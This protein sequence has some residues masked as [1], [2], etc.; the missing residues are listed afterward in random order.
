MPATLSTITTT[1]PADQRTRAV[2]VW[3]AVAGG[4][5][6]LG[7]LCSGV[8][9]EFF[10]WRSVFVVNIV[11]AVMAL[12]GTLRFVPESAH[13]ATSR[14]DTIGAALAM[15]GLVVLVFSI[16]EAS[17][18]GWMALRTLIGLGLSLAVL[19]GFV[20]WEL[21]EE[22]P[23][24]DP[25]LFSSRLLTAG[26]SS[27]FV[28][29]V[30]FYGF[31]FVTLQYLQGVR[32]YSPFVAT[33]CVL[34]LSVTMM[35]IA[36]ST[37]KL[38]AVFGPRAVGAAGLAILAVGLVVISQVD[39]NSSYWLLLAGLIPL[40]AGIGLATVPATTAITEALPRSQ[41]GVG[42]A[43]ND[44]SRE[45]GGALG[46]AV[47]GSILAATYR[48]KLPL[49]GIPAPL[50]DRARSSFAVA[51]H[52]GGSVQAT[53][54]RAF[55]DG[56]R[57]ALLCAAAAAVLAAVDVAVLQRDGRGLSAGNMKE[58]RCRLRAETVSPETI[59][60][61]SGQLDADVSCGPLLVQVGQYLAAIVIWPV[62]AIVDHRLLPSDHQQKGTS[63]DTQEHTHLPTLRTLDRTFSRSWG[64]CGCCCSTA[65][66]LLY[67]RHSNAEVDS[68][69]A[70]FGVSSQVRGDERRTS[71]CRRVSSWNIPREPSRP[72]RRFDSGDCHEQERALVHPCS[73]VGRTS[74]AATS[75]HL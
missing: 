34:P 37:P 4:S 28:Q 49:S 35:P 68:R 54:D 63:D 30:C 57:I 75:A 17:D 26:S 53:A 39:T 3:A 27:I 71:D 42:S 33:L 43:L 64:Q 6:V 16:I 59:A 56:L 36:G 65:R 47:V 73:K 62:I 25:R 20:A 9:L 55:V 2:G 44:L 70:V 12:A 50:A 31:A 72:P 67:W 46:I 41:Q 45:V 38:V 29:F 13:P 18:V 8:L 5:A 48:S 40:G 10:S 51:V 58:E 19:A 11:V 60:I 61:E 1:Y 7:L 32:G 15:V 23:L 22:H 14:L 66:G 52:A 69:E 74:E 21:H 24:L